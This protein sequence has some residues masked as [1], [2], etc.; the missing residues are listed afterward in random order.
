MSESLSGKRERF[1]DNVTHKKGKFIAN[2]SQGS[3]RI[4][5]SGEGSESPEPK[6]LPKFIGYA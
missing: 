5:L 3:C 6:L 2:L 1:Q 4:E